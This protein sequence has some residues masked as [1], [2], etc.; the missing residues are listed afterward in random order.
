MFSTQ[1]L[2]HTIADACNQFCFEFYLL[3][4]I[5]YCCNLFCYVWC[6]LDAYLFMYSQMNNQSKKVLHAFQVWKET[7]DG[8]FMLA[9]VL[10]LDVEDI[11][12]GRSFPRLMKCH[13]A[14]GSQQWKW[15]GLV[16]ALHMYFILS[17][18]NFTNN[19]PNLNIWINF[20]P[21]CAN[22]FNDQA[23]VYRPDK[24][25]TNMPQISGRTNNFTDISLVHV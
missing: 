11:A 20:T 15:K 8:Y 21:I 9:G 12:M 25:L 1:I 2:H 4:S 10:C 23:M 13:F 17:L 24:S 7:D 19:R 5:L 3:W 18:T 6:P 16:R 22:H 14:K